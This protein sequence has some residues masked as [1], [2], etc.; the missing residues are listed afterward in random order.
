MFLQNPRNELPD[1]FL[2]FA[3]PTRLRILERLAQAGEENVND[4]AEFLH[5]S[6]P[7]ISWHLRML[8]VGGVIK[9][10]REGRQVYCSL[11]V[12]NIRRYRERLDQML[13]MSSRVKVRE[14]VGA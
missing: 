12:E 6:Q 9:T 1:H 2:G 5:M 14:E 7:R 13:G 8:R 3:N 11:D 4:L 10:R